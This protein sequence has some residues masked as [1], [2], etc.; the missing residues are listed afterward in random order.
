MSQMK[1]RLQ[2]LTLLDRAFNA[3]SDDELAAA[4]AALPDDHREALDEVCG[5]REGGFSDPAARTLALRATAARGRVNGGLEQISTLISDPCLAKCIELL[6]D[7]SDNP[8]EAQ[9]LEATPTLI[10]EFG[11]AVTRLMLA[12]SVAGEAAASEMLTSV[13]KHDDTL[14]LPPAPKVE[15]ELRPAPS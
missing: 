3:I 5:A 9:L 6:G 10:K 12:T 15:V 13:L 4:V 7:N 2:A 11:V 14:A 1:N 8:T